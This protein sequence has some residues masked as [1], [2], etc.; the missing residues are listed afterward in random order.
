ML[1]V[2]DVYLP[3]FLWFCRRLLSIR[4]SGSRVKDDSFAANAAGRAPYLKVSRTCPSKAWFFDKKP[5][6]GSCIVVADRCTVLDVS[7]DRVTGS[8]CSPVSFHV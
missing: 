2:M 3:L 6:T 7:D 1:M 8:E 5:E 4:R